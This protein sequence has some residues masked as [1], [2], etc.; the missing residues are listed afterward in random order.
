MKRIL[1]I[2]LS[3]LILFS[4]SYAISPK[5]QID[6][7]RKSNSSFANPNYAITSHKIGAISLGIANNGTIGKA[8]SPVSTDYFT[9]EEIN[10]GHYPIDSQINYLFG[11][12]IW[13]GARV[14]QDTLVSVGSDGWI[15][16]QEFAPS[17]TTSK[18]IIHR[19]ILDSESPEYD[20]AISEEDYVVEF[21]DTSV[22][23]EQPHTPLGIKVTLTSMAWSKSYEE[24][25]ILLNYKIE[26][27]GSN[28]LEDVYVGFLMDSDVGYEPTCSE[29][30]C[31]S[32]DFFG[33]TETEVLNF[34]GCEFIDTINMLWISDNDGDPILGEWDETS[35]RHVV[36]LSI[37]SAPIDNIEVSYNWWKVLS[38]VNDFGPRHKD[39]SWNFSTGGDG[40]P[41]T[42]EDMYYMMSNHEQDYDQFYTAS[43]TV[44]DPVWR[45]PSQEI[46]DLIADGMD[47]EFLLSF[48]SFDLAP[49][50]VFPF[51]MTYVGGKNLHNDV[52]NLSNL[53]NNPDLYR[54][55]LDFTDLADSRRW[56]SWVYDNP[57]IDTDGNGD[58]GEFV[59]CNGDIYWTK[60]DSVPDFK[61]PTTINFDPQNLVFVLP[62][63]STELPDSQ[64]IVITDEDSPT[65][66]NSWDL[67]FVNN[68]DWL[69][70]NKTEG[71]Y[72][73]TIIFYINQVLPKGVYHELIKVSDSIAQNSPEY[74]NISY[75]VESGV[76]VGDFIT[77]P[78]R[79]FSISVQLNSYYPFVGFTI[80]LKFH[81]DQPENITLDSIVVDTSIGATFIK[82][83]DTTCVVYRDIEEPILPDSNYQV[84]SL[85]F[86]VEEGA[87]EELIS[88]DSTLITVGQITY[89]YGI[90][91][92][93][94]N[95]I[96]PGFDVGHITIVEQ[97]CIGYRGNVDA[98]YL[99][100]ITIIDLVTLIEF[101]FVNKKSIICPE[102]ADLNAD[103]ELDIS[104]LTYLV[105]Y[106]FRNGDL[107]VDCQIEAKISSKSILDPDIKLLKTGEDSTILSIDSEVDLKGIY[108]EIT[109]EDNIEIK[110]LLNHSYDLIKNEN[111][112]LIK[113]GM[114]DSQGVEHISKGKTELLEIVGNYEI[115][116]IIVSDENHKSHYPKIENIEYTN[117]L[118]DNYSLS[119]NYPNPFN[120]N[121]KIE[122]ALPERSVVNI[123]VFNILGQEVVN[124]I[125][126]ELEA[127]YYLIDW[128]G[129][130]SSGGSVTSGV[131]FYKIQA[132][133]F[134][135]TKKMMLLK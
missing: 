29:T 26:N 131:Y 60:G 51:T 28:F 56:A 43:I 13:I 82:P 84:A 83:D 9:G 90:E 40:R 73:D 37:V 80:P 130:N 41:I 48:G 76:D 58:A 21:Y 91:F 128:D 39:D 31:Y 63:N 66:F 55:N 134:V 7:S 75:F 49:G 34:N 104:D 118:P 85:Y 102:E 120:P 89:E 46:K 45:E 68:V 132:G 70:V 94:K 127:G 71:N 27:I 1:N 77:Y 111:R 62:E 54:E 20:F 18:A 79:E 88:I 22:T 101:V 42:D 57:G 38:I 117:L 116:D 123:C 129:T 52:N 93:N 3:T 135:E 92:A 69:G 2:T 36:G 113:L 87:Y 12:A 74:I 112:N 124:L 105:D 59:E 110:Q 103:N 108:I 4:L 78:G 81:T 126:E 95:Q 96:E 100:Q 98:S 16:K 64:I 30:Q 72:P 19:S 23:I 97:C 33:F 99:D 11:G 122:F 106:L 10:S 8:F 125:D 115:N 107:P 133:D 65:P 114:F 109:S 14:G 32:D 5:S 47:V 61:S 44:D 50:E 15:G 121:T 53:P 67:S 25:F 24:D 119:Q 17:D 86:S 6:K 35:A